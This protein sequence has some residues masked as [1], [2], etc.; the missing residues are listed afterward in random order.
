MPHLFKDQGARPIVINK[1]ANIFANPQALF[2]AVQIRVQNPMDVMPCLVHRF[3]LILAI[4]L[5]VERFGTK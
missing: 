2:G 3:P 5:V 1:P 4:V